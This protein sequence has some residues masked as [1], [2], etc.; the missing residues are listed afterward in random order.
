MPQI[1][2]C[3]DCGRKLRV[4]DNLLGKKVKCP[5]CGVKFAAQVEEEL[6]ELEELDEVEEPAPSPRRPRGEGVQDKPSKSRRRED[7]EEEEEDD[8]DAEPQKRKP[9]KRDI[10]TGWERVRLGVNLVA[11]SIW[12]LVCG[13]GV[14]VASMIV[15]G[16]LTAG[17]P[18]AQDF[19][20]FVIAIIGALIGLA[21]L[22]SQLTGLGFCM[23]VVSTPR[24]QTL[25]V[26][27]IA[28]FGLGITILILQIFSFG[29]ARILGPNRGGIVFVGAV[30]LSNSTV[31][32]LSGRV[33]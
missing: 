13:L 16:Q 32:V 24:T 23:G 30:W 28:A 29:A 8:E 2:S 10:Y 5:G 6:E 33:C 18:R 7:E 15:I 1:I 11:M 19:A 26:L 14:L 20:A 4:P 12:I 27:A 17:S 21:S 31:T 22:G 25:K 9:K 3:P